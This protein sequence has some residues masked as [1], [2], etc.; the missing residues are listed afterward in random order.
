MA[1]WKWQ[2]TSRAP[3]EHIYS[4]G[5][6]EYGEPYVYA[7]GIIE[8]TR[9]DARHRAYLDLATGKQIIRVWRIK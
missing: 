9:Q 7:E 1:K 8:G 3:L 5:S 2:V 6:K 4:D